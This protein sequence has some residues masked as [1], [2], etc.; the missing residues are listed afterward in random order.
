MDANGRAGSERRQPAPPPSGSLASSSLAAVAMRPT[1]LFLRI[2]EF[3]E[4]ARVKPAHFPTHGATC[5]RRRAAMANPLTRAFFRLIAGE[6][7]FQPDHLRWVNTVYSRS[8]PKPNLPPG[9]A[10]R[11][12]GTEP[13]SLDGFCALQTPHPPAHACS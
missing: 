6:K 2:N 7:A 10:H 3:H 8:P 4:G 12:S 9:P 1:S 13:S 11:L 5:Q